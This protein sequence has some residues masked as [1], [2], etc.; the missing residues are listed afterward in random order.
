[1]EEKVPD[2]RPQYMD[3]FALLNKCEQ[4]LLNRLDEAMPALRVFCQVSMSQ[5]FHIGYRRGGYRQLGEI[6]RKSVDFLVVRRSDTS[7]VVAIELNGPTHEREKQ[8]A[9]DEKKRAAL[10]EAGIPLLVFY[11]DALPSVPE[12]R[13]AIAPFIAK[14]RRYEAERNE[15]LGRQ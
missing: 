7:I 9:S 11:P 10:E 6:G 8:K 12:L 15:R 2:A 3:K 1:M 13:E 4:D 5:L 14:R